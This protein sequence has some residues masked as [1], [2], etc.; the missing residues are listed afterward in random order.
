M[1]AWLAG[2]HSDF[3]MDFCLDFVMDVCLE[4]T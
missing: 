1:K 4:G 2:T 3:I